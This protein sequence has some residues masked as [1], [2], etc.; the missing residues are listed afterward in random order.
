MSVDSLSFT[1]REVDTQDDIAK[2]CALRAACYGRHA[3]ALREHMAHPDSID[4]SPWT[5]IF[6]CEDKISGAPVG[7]MRVVDNT[8]G[9]TLEIEQY[10]EVPG[11]M[12]ADTRGEMTRLVVAPGSD[13]LVKA[14]LWKAGYV[15]CLQDKVQWLVIGARKP[16]LIKQYQYLGAKD[17]YADQRLV[18]LGHG[19]SLP[20]R[21]FVLNIL[22]AASDW[23]AGRHRLLRFMVETEHPDI[24]ISSMHRPAAPVPRLSLVASA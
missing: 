13:P 16:G 20:H 4:R 15:R 11:W 12:A 2:V 9:T 17:M 14:A 21:I 10:L 3:H 6:L 18:P 1:V 19:W 24:S 23:Y 5:S 7:T 8:R 22:T